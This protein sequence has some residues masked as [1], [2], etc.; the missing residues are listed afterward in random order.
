MLGGDT[1]QITK[2]QCGRSGVSEDSSRFQVLTMCA[3]K[4]SM[5]HQSASNWATKSPAD[6]EPDKRWL[7]SLLCCLSALVT[8]VTIV[9]VATFLVSADDSGFAQDVSQGMNRVVPNG[10][11]IAD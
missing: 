7:G 1:W 9:V 5:I 2:G 6:V 4:Q 8:T 11:G 10:G 3:R